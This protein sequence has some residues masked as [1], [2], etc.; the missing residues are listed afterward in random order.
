MWGCGALSDLFFGEVGLGGIL[1]HSTWGVYLF[2][3]LGVGL[4]AWGVGQISVFC[5][6]KSCELS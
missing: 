5:S 6:S 4:E 2:V 1:K 3:G